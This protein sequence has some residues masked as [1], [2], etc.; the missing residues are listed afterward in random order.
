MV[1]DMTTGQRLSD[2]G[3]G[4]SPRADVLPLRRRS[5]HRL[6]RRRGGAVPQAH[7]KNP[8]SAAPAAYASCTPGSRTARSRTGRCLPRGLYICVY[9]AADAFPIA[10]NPMPSR[11][12]GMIVRGRPYPPRAALRG[13]SSSSPSS[14]SA[15]RSSPF[16]RKRA[17]QHP[18]HSSFGLATGR[19]QQ[20]R[21]QSG[22]RLTGREPARRRSRPPQSPTFG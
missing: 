22:Y 17:P 10:R 1:D 11:N 13:D 19:G 4:E 7:E 8:S 12:E 15:H 18:D 21:D 2:G 9:T 6:R 16:R 14:P 20:G 5:L 3:P